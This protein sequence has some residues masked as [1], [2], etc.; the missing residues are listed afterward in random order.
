M[1]NSDLFNSGKLFIDQN[2]LEGF[3]SVR[4]D[5]SK[6]YVLLGT[7]TV[8]FQNESVPYLETTG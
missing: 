1:E 7:V 4:P 3:V 8:K 2:G 5:M 6:S